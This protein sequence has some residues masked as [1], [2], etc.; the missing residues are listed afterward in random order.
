VSRRGVAIAAVVVV[1][2]GGVAI[3]VAGRLTG[4]TPLAASGQAASSPTGSGDPKGQAREVAAALARLVSDPN[5]LM[6]SGAPPEVKG[7]A[8]LAVPP[9]SRVAVNEGSWA[10]DGGTVLV[11][12]STPGRPSATYAAVMVR[13]NDEWKVLATFPV[14]PPSAPVTDLTGA[15]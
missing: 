12:L 6:A 10:P 1:L 2:F 15:P 7:R 8:S 14:Q 13:E 11:A 4:G 9:G 5:L 3:Y